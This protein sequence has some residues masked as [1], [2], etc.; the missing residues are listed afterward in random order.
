[1]PVLSGW[2]Q[3]PPIDEVRVNRAATCRRLTASRQTCQWLLQN[4]HFL[5]VHL[6]LSHA[7]L[8]LFLLI[9]DCNRPERVQ[10]VKDD[11]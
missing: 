4:E 11:Q 7:L 1:M 5:I 10:L 3:R 8:L 6:V 2:S 9:I